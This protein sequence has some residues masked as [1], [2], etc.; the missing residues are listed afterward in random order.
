MKNIEINELQLI[1][2]EIVNINDTESSEIIGGG[3]AVNVSP[4]IKT[5]INLSL[6]GN[7]ASPVNLGSGSIDVG[8]GIYVRQF[9]FS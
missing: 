7:F 1:G 4:V 2:N 8:Q 6:A 5:S 9:N 3:I